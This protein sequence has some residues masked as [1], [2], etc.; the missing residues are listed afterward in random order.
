[1]HSRDLIP[2]PRLLSAKNVL[3]IFPHPDDAEL[4]AGGTVAFLTRNGASVTYAPATDGS[5][6]SL[7][8]SV[9]PEQ[10]AEIRK[11]ELEAAGAVLGV[12]EIIWLGYKDGFTPEPAEMREGM[13]TII[14]KVRPDF[15][16]TLDPWLPYEAHPDH[17]KVSMAAVEACMYASF[18]HAY[19]GDRE[20]GL[21]PWSVT[22]VALGLSPAPNTFID[23]SSTWDKKI[24]AMLCHKSQF[25]EPIWNQVLPYMQL[26]AQEYGKEIGRDLAEPFKVLSLTHLHVNIDAW[27]S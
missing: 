7:D 16:I 1:M 19:P 4:A 6:G 24:E 9:D 10:M 5:L 13:V 14:R 12:R 26:K 20:R 17:R 22:G 25:P 23:V 11:K 21:E 15:V 27:R 8:P 18:I 3:V 2:V